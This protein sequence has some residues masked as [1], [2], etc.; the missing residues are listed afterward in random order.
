MDT[1]P[2]KLP[3]RLPNT[4][5]YNELCATCQH[6]HHIYSGQTYTGYNST[7]LV[8]NSYIYK[9]VACHTTDCDCKLFVLDEEKLTAYDSP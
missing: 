3:I 9:T 4:D 7:N 8:G 2:Q 5:Y 1:S 6:K